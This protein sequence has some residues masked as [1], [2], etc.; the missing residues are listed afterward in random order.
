MP[1]PLANMTPIDA[2][3]HDDQKNIM[4]DNIA[5]LDKVCYQRYSQESKVKCF[6]ERFAYI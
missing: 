6:Y 1:D 4:G 2:A 5:N 3:H